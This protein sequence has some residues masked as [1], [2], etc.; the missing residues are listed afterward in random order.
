MIDSI[1]QFQQASSRLPAFIT[2]GEYMIE[3]W[4]SA[5][6]PFE[7]VQN[8]VLHLCEFCLKY[9]KSK[10]ILA[11]HLQKKCSQYQQKCNKSMNESMNCTIDSDS[12]AISTFSSI[13]N[14]G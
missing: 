12:P 11:L 13:T 7:Y 14:E 8:S 6:Y 4:Y 2:F 10:E 5:P 1:N 9:V 3:T